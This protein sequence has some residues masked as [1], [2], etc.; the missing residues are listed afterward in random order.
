[1]KVISRWS[2]NEIEESRAKVSPRKWGTAVRIQNV[3]KELQSPGHSI[4]HKRLLDP[5]QRIEIVE[6]NERIE[7]T[8]SSR[9]D[10][11]KRKAAK[12]SRCKRGPEEEGKERGNGI[13]NRSRQMLPTLAGAVSG[14][15]DTGRALQFS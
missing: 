14:W 6:L 8:G 12:A 10:R 13:D 15:A 4:G 11:Q 5:E 1:M 2:G 9:P 3:P 7:A